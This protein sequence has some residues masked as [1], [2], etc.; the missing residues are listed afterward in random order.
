[1]CPTVELTETA[2]DRLEELQAEIRRE[3]GRDVSKRVLLER[4]VRAAYES[5]DEVVDQFRDD[6][7][8]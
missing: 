2:T 8:S 6:S 7:P 3:T 4:I 1:M 5:R